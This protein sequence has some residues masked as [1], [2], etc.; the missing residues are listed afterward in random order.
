MQSVHTV[1]AYD[2]ELKF[3]SKRIAAMGGH[4]ERM[5]EQAIAAL[6]NAEAVLGARAEACRKERGMLPNFVAV[7]F[8]DQGDLFAVVDRLNGV[9]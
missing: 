4:A 7:D 3:L 9:D 1:S 5:V 8:Y 6:V 2:E